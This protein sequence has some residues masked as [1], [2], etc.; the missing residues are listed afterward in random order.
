MQILDVDLF[1]GIKKKALDGKRK[2]TY[3]ESY[4]LISNSTLTNYQIIIFTNQE[5][6]LLKIRSFTLI[7]RISTTS[8]FW[9]NSGNFWIQFQ[10]IQGH[11]P[12]EKITN[13]FTQKHYL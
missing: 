10:P 2:I 3:A 4:K 1:S 13:T 7:S 8:N 11:E 6:I 9:I 5:K 12:C